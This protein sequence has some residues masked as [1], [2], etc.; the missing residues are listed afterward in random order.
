MNLTQC[1]QNLQAV[2][3]KN[4]ILGENISQITSL[5]WGEDKSE[6]LNLMGGVT[7]VKTF[8]FQKSSYVAPKEATKQTHS[9]A[10]IQTATQVQSTFWDDIGIGQF[11]SWGNYILWSIAILILGLILFKFVRKL[12]HFLYDVLNAHRMVYLK[13]M[14]PRNDGK[15]DREQQKE[16]AKDMKEKIGRMSQVFHN[17]HKLGELSFEDSFLHWLF[18]KP[19]V[20]LIYHYED[21]LLSFI[22]GTYPEYQKVVEGAISAQYS[23]CSIEV[24]KQPKLF[25]KKHSDIMPLVPKKKSVYNIRL[26]KQMSDDPINN[27]IDAMAKVSRY[28]TVSVV[29]PIKPVGEWMNKKAQKRSNGLYRN[30]KKYTD[31][32]YKIKSF[33]SYLNPFKLLGLLIHGPKDKN[34]QEQQGNEVGGKDFVRMVK[35]K[36]DYL[37]SMGEEA[38]LPYYEGGLMLITTSDDKSKL[39]MNLDMLLSSYNVY[40]DEYGNEFK[41]QNEKHDVFGF[42]FLSLWKFA[43]LF[44]LTSFFF[45]KHYFGVNELASLFHFPDNAYNRSPIVSWMQYKVLPAPDNL[46]VLNDFGGYVMS[47]KL[48]ENYKGGNLSA[49]LEEYPKH[50]AV[51][52]KIEKEEK[53][54]PVTEY[55]PEKLQG[56]EI[57]E[58]DGH[59]FVKEIVDKKV[60]GYKIFRDG[61]LLGLNIYRNNYSPVYMKRNDRTRHHYCIG[62]SGTGKSVFLQTIARQ[63]IWNGDGIC[64]V[65]PHG[66]LAEDVLAYIPKERAKDVV[67]F[68]AGNEDRPMGLNLYE[69]QSL[70]DADRVVNDATEIFLK[71]FGPEIFGP[72]IQE[73][74]KYGSLTLLEDFDDRP[75][76]L[77]VV[78]LFTDESYREYKC[79]KVTN[80]TVR[81][82]WEKTFNSMGDREKA[83]IIPYFSAKFVSFNTNRLIRNIIGQTKSA[84]TF[85]DIMN[86]QKILIINLS[87]GKIGELNAQLLGMIIVS[88][89]YTS[90]MARAKIPESERKDF[91]LYVDEFQN[92]VSGTFADILSEARKYR[93]CLIMAHQYIAQLEPAKGLGG[94][95]GGKGDVKAAVFG[96]VGTMQSFKVGA[97]DAEFLEKEYQPVLS[98]QDI[99]GIANYKAYIKLNIDNS[100]TRVFSMNAIYTKDYQ[101]PK[102]VPILKEYSAK[103]Y[104]RKREFVDAEMAAR[105]GVSEE[106]QVPAEEAQVP[107]EVPQIPN[108]V[109]V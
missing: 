85:E 78:R 48:A 65:D 83:E 95:Q 62:K 76:L 54:I 25:K 46:P 23:D 39:E 49:V 15:G 58:K 105:L 75:T 41:D 86:N 20:N 80:P 35:A 63:D 40:G 79:K 6:C 53:I 47:G 14:L 19:K 34:P 36:E 103:K 55:K 4:P 100:T 84:F 22:V 94:D 52:T 43:A 97:P 92:F 69:I 90:A 18:Y 10:P 24:V 42:F 64:L 50:R 108:P 31:P 74:F 56:K 13:V 71:M 67:Y 16:I 99:V 12:L 51:G 73:Y 29:I 60:N 89:I 81:N 45:K 3:E 101:N 1:E 8:I 88:K 93:L 98:Q 82:R 104:G 26:Y 44:G 28:D 102:I 61:V 68:D 11:L 57:I 87:K 27:L 2:Y 17:L 32:H 59:K 33:F 70:D 91:Y 21:G 9:A 72:R 5:A 106:S 37:N 107:A 7:N 30:D 38:S 109:S 77:D 96:N 66:D